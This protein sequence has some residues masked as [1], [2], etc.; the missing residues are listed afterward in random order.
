MMMQI[1]VEMRKELY[2]LLGT[3]VNSIRRRKYVKLRLTTEVKDSILSSIRAELIDWLKVN[4]LR[5]PIQ[6]NKVSIR[7]FLVQC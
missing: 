1:H 3:T 5:F 2:I 7:L 4:E 6:S